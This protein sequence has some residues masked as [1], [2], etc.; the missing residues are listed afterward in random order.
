MSANSQIPNHIAINICSDVGSLDVITK[1]IHELIKE[2]VKKDIPIL[3]C[4]LSYTND[5]VREFE[6]FFNKL[7]ND[8]FVHKHKIKIVV[9]G[10]WYDTGLV[11]SI[12]NLIDVTSEYDTFF[13]AFGINYSGQEEIVRALRI[14]AKKFS[15]QRIT[16]QDINSSLIKDSLASSYFVPPELIIETDKQ[17]SGV[18]LWD[19]P[20]AII[21]HDPRWL[22]SLSDAISFRK[23]VLSGQKNPLSILQK[24]K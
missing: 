6:D 5:Y 11:E 18:V 3:T 14:I 20:G 13:V 10:Q 22:D 9:I 7:A 16:L 21:Y 23:K 17:Y 24:K 8:E 4:N 2:Q 1:K 15:E 12:K 19:A